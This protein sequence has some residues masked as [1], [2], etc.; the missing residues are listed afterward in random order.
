MKKRGVPV[1]PWNLEQSSVLLYQPFL[2]F[3]H[4]LGFELPVDADK[5]FVRIPEFWTPEILF[6][7]AEKLGPIDQGEPKPANVRFKS[8]V[9]F[10]SF[11]TLCF[12]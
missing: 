3:L 6:K 8:M 11:L 4:R 7:V 12:H 10:S 1:I 5:L 2:L 9:F